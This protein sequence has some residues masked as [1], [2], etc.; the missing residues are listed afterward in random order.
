VAVDL[1]A[2]AVYLK[3]SA[4]QED[5]IGQK[6]YGEFLL[7]HRKPGDD[8]GK[9][10]EDV[11]LAAAQGSSI[12]QCFCGRCHALGLGTARDLRLAI[13]YFEEAAKQNHG[14]AECEL[15]ICYEF[16]FVVQRNV[17]I[18]VR[19]YER[20]ASHDAKGCGFQWFGLCCEFG[21][22]MAKDLVKACECYEHGSNG[23]EKR[24]VSQHCY[25]FCLEHGIGTTVDTVKA[26][27]YYQKSSS[28]RNSVGSF[29]YAL[30]LQF[31]RGFDADLDDASDYYGAFYQD[32]G[33]REDDRFRCLRVLG[34]AQFDWRQF[35]G[36]LEPS[37]E[38]LEECRAAR[39]HRTELSVADFALE[40]GGDVISLG[41]LAA[42]RSST[43][44]LV[45]HSTD[46]R[47]VI[48]YLD[49][50]TESS[51]FVREVDALSRLNHVCIVR[52]LGFVLPNGTGRAE[53]HLEHAAHGSLD[54]ILTDVRGGLRPKWWTNT[55]LCI[56]ICGIVL[57]LRYVHK[58]G[59]I[60]QDLKPSNILINGRY[61][62]LIADFGTAREDGID[63]TPDDVNGTVQYAAPEQ[64]FAIHPSTKVDVFSFGLI[65]YEIVVG[66]PVFGANE[67]PFSII[68]KLRSHYLPT[69]PESV[70]PW[71]RDLIISCLSNE[72][73]I[74][75]TADDLLLMIKSRQFHILEGVDISEV[76][77]YVGGVEEWEGDQIWT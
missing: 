47:R 74:R 10:F 7:E 2:A 19:Y 1:A 57:G 59:F 5:P 44:E 60:H 43:V 26:G 3:R 30:C 13:G 77:A 52:L 25:G 39:P 64:F 48:K 12:A 33:R 45:N 16:G 51:T 56:I 4:D 24:S 65:L 28:E 53:I 61:R 62:A 76:S 58:C 49:A 27:L 17:E 31:G 29:H 46:F 34:Q 11:K 21:Q 67:A 50:N 68:R 14:P 32:G 18:A 54:E 70:F 41:R 15:G 72:P 66:R 20:A 9:L 63:L 37:F 6:R 36:L 73:S 38:I 8:A 75:P 22:G 42:G 23:S 69:I 35:P 40:H 55:N 71:I